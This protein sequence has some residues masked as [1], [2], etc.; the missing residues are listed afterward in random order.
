M[1]D[2]RYP[3]PVALRP[4]P[5]APP[6][7][8][9]EL[10][11]ARS[12]LRV[13]LAGG[14]TDI[15]SYALRYG[16]LVIGCAIDRFVAVTVYPREFRG[17]LRAATETYDVCERAHDHPDEMTRACLLRAGLHTDTQIASFGDVPAGS[18]LGGSGAFTVSLL[19]AAAACDTRSARALATAA[20][21]VEITDLG[22]AVGRQ[23]HYMAAYGGLRV[24]RFHPSG[25]VEPDRLVLTPQTR[26]AL[27]ERLMLFH[28]GITRDAGD[29]LAEQ[30]RRTLAG[31][32]GALRRLHRIRR[33]A[34]EMTEALEQG[35]VDGVGALV[36]EHWTLK[37]Q[38]G[39][40]VSSP[41]LQA[42]HDRAVEA[43][44]DG[45]KLLGSGGGG[46]LLLVC[47]PGRQADVRASLAE[48]GLREMPF[49]FTD[50]GSEVVRLPL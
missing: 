40:R 31:H 35:E 38:L 8:R 19:H 30:N 37:S 20:S 2:I 13:S 23:D 27:E 6:R 7:T 28:T 9:P 36:D 5:E 15:P 22:R 34:D 18:G 17:R 49:R 10:V 26:A 46:F 4:A 39:S 14:G 42:L 41:R 11:T 3:A 25:H 24:L 12:P 47:A 44:A 29:I 45:G 43:G 33:I 32:H 21:E 1:T 50:S 16:G 48:V